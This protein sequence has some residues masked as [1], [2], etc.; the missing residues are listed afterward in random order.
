MPRRTR[1]L[2]AALLLVAT[3]I[4]ILWLA[5]GAGAPDDQTRFSRI[6]WTVR[7]RL[8]PDRSIPFFG[9]LWGR[10]E[11]DERPPTTY[12]L[13]PAAPLG[14]L[15][16]DELEPNW[17]DVRF[18][19]CSSMSDSTL[20]CPD[21]LTGRHNVT[22]QMGLQDF[23]VSS[24]LSLTPLPARSAPPGACELPPA[25]GLDERG[26]AACGPEALTGR[27][28]L[29]WGPASLR[30]SSRRAHA[31]ATALAYTL[32]PLRDAPARV[33]V[34]GSLR[35]LAGASRG[36]LFAWKLV[37]LDEQAGAARV[38]AEGSFSAAGG[39][40]E[41]G[42]AAVEAEAE[43][44]GPHEAAALWIEAYPRPFPGPRGA[45]G[46]LFGL[47]DRLSF[48]VLALPEGGVPP[49]G[50]AP[51]HAPG[52]PAALAEALVRSKVESLSSFANGGRCDT[53]AARA[54]LRRA[55]NVLGGAR[56]WS[57]DL[58]ASP[59]ACNAGPLA[60][61]GVNVDFFNCIY[62][63]GLCARD[64]KV[65]AYPPP[66]LPPATSRRGGQVLRWDEWR[67]FGLEPC[68]TTARKAFYEA[69][70]DDPL[71]RDADFY[72]CSHP[73]A[74]C[75]LYVP[76]NRSLVLHAT[77]RLEFGRDDDVVDWRQPHR[78]PRSPARWK[79]WGA[80]LKRVAS[81]GGNVLAAN[82]LYDL[83]YITYLT[84]LDAEY[85]PSWCGYARAGRYAPARRE[86]LLGPYRDNLGESARPAPPRPARPPCPT[87]APRRR[88]GRA[89]KGRAAPDFAYIADLYGERYE[90][91]DL[92]AH[93]AIVRRALPFAAPP[94]P[95]RPPRPHAA[96][97]AIPYQ[98]S[99]MS[100]FEYYRLN[101]PLFFPSPRLL[102]EWHQ[103]HGVTW[104]RVY[105]HPAGLARPAFAHDPN[106]DAC[107]DVA[108]W[109]RLADFYVWPHVRT[110]D[111]WEELLDALSDRDALRETSARMAEHNACLEA[112]VAEAWARV[113]G[114]ASREKGGRLGAG[115]AGPPPAEFE[116][117][118]R[119]LGFPP[120]SP[121]D[122]RHCGPHRDNR[123][124]RRARLIYE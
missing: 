123:G 66:A 122:P 108:F 112:D 97:A 49:A 113:L 39:A 16:T 109:A 31:A 76:F 93:P 7:T 34:R 10:R 35:P 88:S 121:D 85:I 40:V 9:S 105:G 94:A 21:A 1:R 81:M 65:N 63:E 6:G 62:Y 95:P 12:Q 73:L 29:W 124:L 33:R 53:R 90:F 43:L 69:Y 77:T 98:M 45:P 61:I 80:T 96:R 119:G 15:G 54:R 115:P 107:P 8:L 17:A 116:E 102:V 79:E 50:P 56:A 70:R 106:S 52:S 32:R 3:S 42:S 71:V 86:V 11:S 26:V 14:P 78:G 27:R 110:F 30:D 84:G 55:R 111:S 13:R 2:I 100:W 89:P 58:H 68:P 24:S 51:R 41:G 82:N 46:P 91:S 22:F 25:S 101:V 99:V 120:A 36:A 64:L 57:T 83:Y 114:R 59:V 74:N 44:S 47:E 48:S 28:V 38:A 18:A 75:E 67:G 87:R 19:A 103:T 92:A 23:C 72:L 104:E 37:V 5:T 60:H 20:S 118:V 4:G 117:A